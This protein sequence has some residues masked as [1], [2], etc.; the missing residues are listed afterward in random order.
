MAI[1]SWTPSPGNLNRYK[2]KEGSGQK[3]YIFE[4]PPIEVTIPDKENVYPPTKTAADFVAVLAKELGPSYFKS[5]KVL[6]MGCGDHGLMAHA[7]LNLGAEK[8]VGSDIDPK[9]IAIVKEHGSGDIGW[10]LSDL[11]NNVEGKFDCIVSNPPQMPMPMELRAQLTD[12]HDSP[13][14]KGYELIIR[15]LQEAGDH[16][17]DKGSL[18]I[19]V[20]DF[21]LS[22]GK[23]IATAREKGFSVK[24]VGE[25]SKPVRRGASGKSYALFANTVPGLR[26]F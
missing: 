10:I 12:W 21:L 6:E 17:T 15:M 18:I 8:V 16:L 14:D 11:F 22:D 20:F 24:F 25:F 4:A 5:K 13:G 23:I 9:S 3:T 1:N 7:V 2:T 19:M 26:I